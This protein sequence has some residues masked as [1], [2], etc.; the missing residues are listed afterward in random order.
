MSEKEFTQE[1]LA[2]AIEKVAELCGL[3]KDF[4]TG[5]L[6]TETNDWSFTIKAH[7]LLESVVCQLI[8]AH[9]EHPSMEYVL[10]QRVQMED[11]IEILKAL[12]IT[13]AD[14]R[15]MMRLLGKIRN[16]LVHNVQQTD[17][18]FS[19]YLQNRDNRRNFTE[20]F[21]RRLPDPVPGTPPVL[22][23]DYVVQYP[24]YAI[25][26]SL[27]D[28]TMVMLETKVEATRRAA[29]DALRKA[30]FADRRGEATGTKSGDNSPN[31]IDD[32]KQQ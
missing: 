21:G 27:L 15:K 5:L 12:G 29:M 13:D 6:F 31:A 28:V 16:N 25:W 19:D 2:N 22:R 23:A 9:L 20:A 7:A 17:F 4:L 3:R 24:R 26:A 1:S 8:A 10:A 18:K 11:R 14:D 32:T 30:R